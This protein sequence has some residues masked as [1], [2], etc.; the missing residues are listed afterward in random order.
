MAQVQALLAQAEAEAHWLRALLHLIVY[1]GMR[2]GEALALTWENVNLAD[3]KLLVTQSWAVSMAGV[4]LESPKT[5]SGNRVVDLD[6]NTVSVLGRHRERQLH[7]AVELGISPPEQV[8]P[9][10]DFS[11]FLHPNTAL[12]SVRQLAARAGCPDVTMRSLRHF[13][14]TLTLQARQNPVVVSKRLGHSSPQSTMEVYAHALEGWQQETAEAFA[15]V[16]RSASQNAGQIGR[17]VLD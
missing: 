5:A 15:D 2:R 13:H 10:G 16:M 11:G 3:R 12:H 14:A 4:L 17:T 9:D 7:I 8:F 6:S 1:T